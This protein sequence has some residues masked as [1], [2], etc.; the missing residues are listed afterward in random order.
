MV[1][2]VTKIPM[3]FKLVLIKVCNVVDLYLTSHTSIKN[4][5]QLNLSEMEIEKRIHN[6]H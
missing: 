4:N 5:F 6:F 3:I 2:I 1:Y